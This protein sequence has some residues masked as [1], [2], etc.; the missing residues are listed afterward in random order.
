MAT[1][2]CDV[3]NMGVNA[4]CADCNKPLVN[5][6][7]TTDAGAVVQV[8]RCPSCEGKIKSPMCCGQDMSYSQ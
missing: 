8:S 5:D 6:T 3:C 1:Y 7:I 4:T 2:R